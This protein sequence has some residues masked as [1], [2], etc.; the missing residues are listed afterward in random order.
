MSNKS[1][2]IHMNTDIYGTAVQKISL[3][4][5]NIVAKNAMLNV[6]IELLWFRD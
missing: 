5:K 1:H 2:F 3:S 6:H 4:S